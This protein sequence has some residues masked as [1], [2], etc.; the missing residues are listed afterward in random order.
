MNSDSVHPS[1][2]KAYCHG[3]ILHKF[4]EN[5]SIMVH[6][7]ENASTSDWNG[8]KVIFVKFYFGD[9]GVVSAE[10]SSDWGSGIAQKIGWTGSLTRTVKSTFARDN[11]REFANFSHFFQISSKELKEK[12][13]QKKQM[14]LLELYSSSWKKILP[15]FQNQ[16]EKE[17][18]KEHVKEIQNI[19]T[20]FFEIINQLMKNFETFHYQNIRERIL[21]K[22]SNIKVHSSM[23]NHLSFGC[24]DY[25]SLALEL[26]AQFEDEDD[27][28][29]FFYYQKVDDHSNNIVNYTRDYLKKLKVPFT[30]NEDYKLDVR[31]FISYIVLRVAIPTDLAYTNEKFKKF[32]NDPKNFTLS[33]PYMSILAFEETLK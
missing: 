14:K 26:R 1:F 3:N 28:E 13:P 30:L 12:I 19:N 8:K 4:I 27:I 2:F 31:Y 29:K 33:S 32:I 9:F 16:Y 5:I 10:H 21:T 11:C 22:A 7:M 24:L 6:E 17:D 15:L 25:H 23:T 20:L 18:K